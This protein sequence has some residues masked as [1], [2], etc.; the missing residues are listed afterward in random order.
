MLDSNNNEINIDELME[1]IRKEI[2]NRRGYS[3]QLNTQ[4][5]PIILNLISNI[6]YIESLLI[7]AESRAYARTKW[8]DK[9]NRFPFNLNLNLQKFILKLINFFF[10][11]QREVNFNLIFALK[12]SGKLNRLLIEEINTLKTRIDEYIGTIDR[13]IHGLDERLNT[14]DNCVQGLDERLST[15]DS[16]FQAMDERLSTVDSRFQ[17]INEHLSIVDTHFQEIV[18][19]LSAME[20]RFQGIDDNLKKSSDYVNNLITEIEQK[21]NALKTHIQAID[22]RYIN[23]D[24]YLKS[25][26]IQQKRLI[27]LFLEEARKRLPEPFNKEQLQTFVEEDKGLLDAFYVAFED[28]F[29]GSRE[30]IF[31]RLKIYLPIIAEAKVGTPE[32]PILDIGCGRGEWLELLRE[33][34]YIAQGIDINKVMVEQCQS[35]GLKVITSEAIS[36]LRSLPNNSLGAITG[37]HIIEH[38]PFA[39]LINLLDECLRVLKPSG[40]IIF[41]TPNPDNVLVGS[42]TFYLDPTHHHPLP[43]SMIQFLAE[44][45]G[46]CRVRTMKLHPYPEQFNLSGSDVAERFNELF[47]GAQDY[48]VIGYKHE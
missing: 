22:E 27:T 37:F 18:Q 29:R 11:D 48:A 24:T 47:Y 19:C 7:N 23:N 35:R 20:I 6:D 41:E 15:V 9:L 45:R 17:A 30:D 44:S 34:G 12:E 13:R 43:S 26:L 33:S 16:C 31:N 46:L 32:S 39:K 25:D 3:Q 1:N 10:K 14:V 38:L 40:L 2:A 4:N 28:K 5:S 8:P 42:N 21:L 36:F